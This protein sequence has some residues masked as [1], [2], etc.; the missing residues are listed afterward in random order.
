M[1]RAS[2]EVKCA[3]QA[4]PPVL[5][6]VCVEEEEEY[7]VPASLWV[8]RHQFTFLRVQ[9]D[10]L[11]AVPHHR[12]RNRNR[13]III[14]TILRQIPHLCHR[15][16][17]TTLP[18]IITPLRRAVD[19]P[20]RCFAVALE[21]ISVDR[22]GLRH[23]VPRQRPRLLL[24]EATMTATTAVVTVR[25]MT[26]IVRRK[27]SCHCG[28]PLHHLKITSH[29]PRDRIVVTA[30]VTSPKGRVACLPSVRKGLQPFKIHISN[31]DRQNNHYLM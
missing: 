24:W 26:T 29:H 6:V 23:L 2:E 16:L 25:W 15:P 19:Q 21:T 10:P 27:F 9:V 14:L 5:A 30:I 18:L 28:H 7:R 1:D 11:M 17:L 31:N 12:L 3:V 4:I 8:A 13:G 20:R 22:L